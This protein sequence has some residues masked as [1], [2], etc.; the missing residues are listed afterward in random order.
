MPATSSTTGGR[1]EGKVAIITGAARGQGAAEAQRFAS[2]GAHVI[3][4]R[5]ARFSHIA[6]PYQLRA[7][8]YPPTTGVRG[9]VS[10]ERIIREVHV[11]GVALV[12]TPGDPGQTLFHV[13]EPE[14]EPETRG[15]I[16]PDWR[17]L[18]LLLHTRV[19]GRRHATGS[20]ELVCS[21]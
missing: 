7:G 13:V 5:C 12:V 8:N 20:V 16:D 6:F 15:R 1:L 2:E 17:V 10:R 3:A 18:P 14:R 4:R 19:Q 21:Q 9:S 11:A